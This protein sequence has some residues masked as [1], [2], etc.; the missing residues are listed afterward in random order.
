MID[1]NMN[2]LVILVSKVQK[3]YILAFP[4]LVGVV[5]VSIC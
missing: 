3:K 5:N 1:N 2:Q 4:L